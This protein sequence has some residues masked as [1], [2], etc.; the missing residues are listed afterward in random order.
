MNRL[1]R[2]ELMKTHPAVRYL[3]RPVPCTAKA[4]GKPCKNMAHWRFR[5]LRPRDG[6]GRVGDGV[7]CWSHLIHHGV[8]GSMDE[9]ARTE[10]WLKR[11]GIIE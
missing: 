11:K 3:K 6:W 5:A 9:E 1:E 2:Q 8:Y 10:R 7:F 4:R